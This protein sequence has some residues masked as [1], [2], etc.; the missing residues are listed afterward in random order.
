MKILFA[1]TPGFHAHSF[2]RLLQ[3]RRCEVDVVSSGAAALRMMRAERHDAVILHLR[4]DDMGGQEVLERARD[5]GLG[6]PVLMLA[7]ARDPMAAVAALRAG[8]DDFVGCPVGIDEL[9]ARLK[10]I[11]RRAAP[12]GEELM[13]V[14]R[15]T[16]DLTNRRASVEGGPVPL[17]GKEYDVLEALARARGRM[18]TKSALFAGLYLGS[19]APSIKIIDVFVC[20]LRKKLVSALGGEDPITTIWGS[21]YAMPAASVPQDAPLHDVAA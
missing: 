19:D 17:T 14:G 4:L 2:T 3:G 20:K 6:V 7:E 18:L 12:Q 13:Q 11:V 21:G 5:A 1:V 15:L 8:A 10:A 9:A 16:L